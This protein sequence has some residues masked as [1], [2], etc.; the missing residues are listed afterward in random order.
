MLAK[1]NLNDRLQESGREY[2]MK[3]ATPMKTA[4]LVGATIDDEPK[5]RV[6]AGVAQR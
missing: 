4:G 1:K 2:A 3:L 5:T 6:G